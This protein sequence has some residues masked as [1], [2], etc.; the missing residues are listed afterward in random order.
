MKLAATT[1]VLIVLASPAC[2]NFL[3]D[4]PYDGPSPFYQLLHT[5]KVF[6]NLDGSSR[7]AATSSAAW[8]FL[9]TVCNQRTGKGLGLLIGPPVD[10]VTAFHEASYVVTGMLMSW[11]PQADACLISRDLLRD[12]ERQ[13]VR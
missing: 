13:K 4:K 2:A 9:E 1:A 10:G 6:M 12:A 11:L 3:P 5:S 7:R 8:A